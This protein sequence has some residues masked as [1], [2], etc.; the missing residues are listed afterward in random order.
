MII[1]RF[2][3]KSLAGKPSHRGRDASSSVVEA[4]GLG[5]SD[6]SIPDPPSLIVGTI[7]TVCTSSAPWS[8]GCPWLR[9]VG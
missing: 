2:L 8:D 4:V 3:H 7:S 1:W 9:Q 6:G 5:S